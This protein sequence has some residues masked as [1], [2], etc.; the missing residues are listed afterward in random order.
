[1]GGRAM[2]SAPDE[3]RWTIYVCPSCGSVWAAGTQAR[4][5]VCTR[6]VGASSQLPRLEPVEVVPA[7]VVEELRE[8]LAW[9]AQ[10]GV[11]PEARQAAR[12]ALASSPSTAPGQPINEGR[13]GTE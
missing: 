3:R 11:A 1:M 4:G 6:H 7:S 13:G 12:N 8:A 2:P 10:Y 9:I 5:N